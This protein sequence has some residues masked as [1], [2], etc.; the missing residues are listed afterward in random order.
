LKNFP[1]IKNTSKSKVSFEIPETEKTGTLHLILEV[2]DSGEPILTRY[3]R[4]ILTVNP[5]KKN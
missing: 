4:V 2:K 3:Q 5:S 1:E